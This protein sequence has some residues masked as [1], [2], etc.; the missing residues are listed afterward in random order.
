[1]YDQILKT[2]K[3]MTTKT[4]TFDVAV[5]NRIANFHKQK[6]NFS[7]Y[8]ITRTLRQAVNDGEIQI[9]DSSLQLQNGNSGNQFL[10]IPH[11]RVKEVVHQLFSESLIPD[12]VPQDNG[13]FINYTYNDPQTAVDPN[14]T[15]LINIVGATITNDGILPPDIK[16]FDT[17]RNFDANLIAKGKTPDK[18]M[19]EKV[20]EYLYSFSYARTAKEIQSRLKGYSVT[21]KEIFEW[22]SNQKDLIVLPHDN[23]SQT[24]IGVL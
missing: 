8:D 22:A 20:S 7:A 15:R 4:L 17:I 1:M 18:E 9:S 12:F 3:T 23:V 13:V 19:W 10:N 16:K 24:E 6:K 5:L 14:P 2:L 21:C 11:G